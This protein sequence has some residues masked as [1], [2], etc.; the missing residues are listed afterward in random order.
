MELKRQKKENAEMQSL[1]KEL[2]KMNLT[3]EKEASRVQEMET[4][5]EEKEGEKLTLMREIDERKEKLASSSEVGNTSLPVLKPEIHDG[6]PKRIVQAEVKDDYG[7]EKD[8]K[9]GRT[10]ITAHAP[11]RSVNFSA[12]ACSKKEKN[13]KDMKK[14]QNSL[15]K[16]VIVE[17]H[18]LVP[19]ALSSRPEPVLL[20]VCT[21]VAMPET[22]EAVIQG[23]CN[24]FT[25]QHSMD[26]K[27]L[28]VDRRF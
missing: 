26:M 23:A 10:P 24:V 5:L 25:T 22:R 28:E 9:F 13:L 21:P 3:C 4:A 8:S 17:G 1:K 20:A 14:D 16:I 11:L 7:I 18:Y 27:I 19:M 2:D 12:S 6:A 15:F